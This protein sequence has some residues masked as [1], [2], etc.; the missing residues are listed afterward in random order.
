MAK[1]VLS[2][3]LV[4]SLSLTGSLALGSP[5]VGMAATQSGRGYRLVASDGGVFSFGDAVFY[6]STGGMALNRPVVGM[7]TTASG[8]RA[9]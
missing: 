4:A 3:F 2:G 8:T 5:V 1:R 9:S 7:A 6:G